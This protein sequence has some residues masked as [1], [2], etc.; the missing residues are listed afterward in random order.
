VRLCLKPTNVQGPC[1]FGHAARAGSRSTG[2]WPRSRTTRTSG[3][4]NQDQWAAEASYDIPKG[5]ATRPFSYFDLV[6]RLD[7][8]KD[9]VSP[10]YS[11]QSVWTFRYGIRA[12]PTAHSRFLKG[13]S[14]FPRFKARHRDRP[15]FTTSGALHLQP[16]RLQVAKYGWVALAAPC[17]A[18]TKLRRLLVRGRAWILNVTVSRDAGGTWHASARTERAMTADPQTYSRPA[19]AT[20]G[21]DVGVKTA[22]VVATCA[23]TL[24]A[25]WK[26]PAPCGT[27]RP[28]WGTGNVPWPGPRKGPRTGPRPGCVWAGPMPVGTVRG[29]RLHQFT[30]KLAKSHAM[31]RVA[32]A[33]QM[34]N[35]HLGQ[36][37]GDQGCGE[38]AGQ[39]G[40]KTIRDGGTPCGGRPVA[41]LK[42]DVLGLWCSETQAVPG[43]GHLPL[44]RVRPGH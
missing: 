17:R 11:E 29:S 16:G 33:N 27:P 38:L 43:R 24:V 36:A 3:P 15:R 13:P 7:A 2:H 34:R 40:D 23:C 9:V 28:T 21:V 26:P 44:R 25:T 41:A 20:V 35:H 30:A 18:Q 42:E 6:R 22:A 14:R 39:L 5:E 12:A 4:H 8:T 10:W 37:I 1:F 31:K 32:T 19:G